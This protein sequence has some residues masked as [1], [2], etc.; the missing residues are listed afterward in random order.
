[1][2]TTLP[3][4]PNP[5]SKWRKVLVGLGLFALTA[6]GLVA[7]FGH[8]GTIKW[9]RYAA[10]LRAR[11]EPLT[12]VEIQARREVVLPERNGAL[13]IEDLLRKGVKIQDSG[14]DPHILVFGGTSSHFD[15]FFGVPKYTI[16]PSREFRDRHRANLEALA[17]LRDKPTG[18]FEFQVDENPLKT[19]LPHLAPLRGLSKLLTLDGTLKLADG[20]V[21]GA[22]DNLPLHWNL[23]AT[24]GDEPTLISQLVRIAIEAQALG[25]MESILRTAV[26]TDEQVTQMAGFLPAAPA[27]QSFRFGLWGE[28]AF[29]VESCEL[30]EEGQLSSAAVMTAATE[31]PMAKPVLGLPRFVL[32]SN[33]LRGTKMYARLIDAL[34]TTGNVLKTAETLENETENLGFTQVVVRAMFPNFSRAMVIHLGRTAFRDCARTALAAERFRLATGDFPKALEELVPKFLAAVPADPFDGKPLRYKAG[35]HGVTIYSIDGNLIDDGGNVDPPRGRK[36]QDRDTG[37]RLFHSARRVVRLTD[38]TPPTD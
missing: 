25:A 31:D 20:D 14:V 33:Q 26:V 36:E 29:F 1:M 34:K 23:S 5:R 22:I 15:L 35:E 2:D 6:W 30:M 38:E 13:V 3:L 12:F 28:R 24:L 11:G 4:P 7:L 17:A 16:E 21:N 8:L 27:D 9:E 18:R 37:F 19:L 32:R 10:E